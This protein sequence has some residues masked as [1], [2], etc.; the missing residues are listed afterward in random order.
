MVEATARQSSRLSGSFDGWQPKCRTGDLAELA[1]E[2]EDLPVLG[3]AEVG[4]ADALDGALVVANRGVELGELE[5]WD[6][7]HAAI[8]SRGGDEGRLGLIFVALK[9][10]ILGEQHV[11]LHAAAVDGAGAEQTVELVV[12][13]VS[14][15]SFAR[16]G[17]DGVIF[18]SQRVGDEQ[19]LF[20]EAR[21]TH[22]DIGLAEHVV[23]FGATGA[24]VEV[25]KVIRLGLGVLRT[26]VVAVAGFA[27]GEQ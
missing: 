19:V 11:V 15:Q 9:Q 13:F 21:A 12:P 27:D 17:K 6:G 20:A 1:S 25:L 16:A 4:H 24:A 22:G 7:A 10:C 5:L 26:L 14:E 8:D 2:V 23:H 3:I 18:K